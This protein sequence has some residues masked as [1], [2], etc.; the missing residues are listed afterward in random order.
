MRY[1][2][3]IC[4]IASSPAIAVR[5]S[6]DFDQRGDGFARVHGGRAD[7][8]AVARQPVTRPVGSVRAGHRWTALCRADLD[9]ESM[10]RAVYRRR[11]GHPRPVGA[12][13]RPSSAAAPRGVSVVDQSAGT[14]IG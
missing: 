9:T 4:T 10:G 2:C 1:R 12:C 7:M 11:P 6:P 14:L 5:E 8:G 13:R 3:S